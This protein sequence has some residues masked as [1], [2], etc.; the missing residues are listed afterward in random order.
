[1]KRYKKYISQTMAALLLG[2][3]AAGCSDDLGFEGNGIVDG[4]PVTLSVNCA[5]GDMPEVSR[6]DMAAGRD[7]EINSMWVAFFAKDGTHEKKYEFT[8]DNVSQVNTMDVHFPTLS[9][10][11]MT[12][13][14]Y[15]LVAVA[16]PAGNRGVT[17]TSTTPSDLMGLLTKVTT[18]E[19]YKNIAVYTDPG[20]VGTPTGNL[21]MQ[22]IYADPRN[23]TVGASTDF[24]TAESE[25]TVKVPAGTKTLA[26]AIHF[27][28]LISQVKFN[29]TY[30][31]QKFS[32]FEPVSATVYNV[33]S[34]S[35][36]AERADNRASGNKETNAGDNIGNNTSNN[37][38]PSQRFYIFSHNANTY[39]IDWYQMEN[40]RLSLE[41]N[42]IS[43]YSDRENERK[44][45]NL[46]TGIYI[47]LC[48]ETGDT[49]LHNNNASYVVIN[50]RMALRD[51]VTTS[52]NQQAT[53]T[54]EAT[55]TIHL[56][57]CEGTNDAE[58]ANDY[59]C[60]R[61]TKYTY[62]ITVK[63]VNKI[64]V[65]AKKQNDIDYEHGAE[66][67]IT[68]ITHDF[69]TADSHFEQFN[70]YF[71]ANELREF[72]WS[73]RVY[74]SPREFVTIDETNYENYPSKY[75]DWIEFVRTTGQNVCA[76]YPAQQSNR[77]KLTDIGK[78]S[79]GYY[80]MFIDEYIY[81]DSGDGTLTPSWKSYVNLPD[82]MAWLKVEEDRSSDTESVI[83]KSK[84]AVQQ[85]SLQTY[86]GTAAN[87]PEQA[88]ALEHVEETDGLSF[89][90]NGFGTSSR[91]GRFQTARM[92]D[93][94]NNRGTINTGN[95][96]PQWNTIL[97]MNAFYGNTGVVDIR[98]DYTRLTH[99]C[100]N[101]N[102]DLN[103]DGRIDASE[104]RWFVPSLN[105][106]VRFVMGAQS[107][108]SP[109]YDFSDKVQGA[110]VNYYHYG[111]S[112]G[113]TLWAEE[114]MSTQ[115]GNSG[116]ISHIR[117]ARYL[118]VNMEEFAETPAEPA[119]IKRDGKNEI[120][121]HYSNEALRDKTT[122]PLP[123]HYVNSEYNRPY[124]SLEYKATS[125]DVIDGNSTN[126]FNNWGPQT[127]T[128]N[129]WFAGIN[130]VNPCARF[131]T[132]DS[133]GWR[134]PNQVELTAILFSGGLRITNL[135]MAENSRFL[136][137]TREFFGSGRIMGATADLATA[138]QNSNMSTNAYILC[139]RDIE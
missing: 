34:Y 130:G 57:Y 66:G 80:T 18:L 58:K 2:A 26:G 100:L 92:L 10:L 118:G 8:Y 76:S 131:N 79:E 114:Y 78:A 69:F 67:I 20:T 83:V 36:L 60:R 29:I 45:N 28:R 73:V 81:E 35:W 90:I 27:R 138:I 40:R 98:S 133:R 72:K 53:R 106:Y 22:G 16:N 9:G 129:S 47:P 102:R 136:S 84:Y 5:V 12:S 126:P 17:E 42:N 103:G 19:E 113:Y 110:T 11:N 25:K 91:G 127:M 52:D 132:A 112:E 117:C 38:T 104:M 65:E 105:Q 14:E 120:E 122:S 101:R 128:V 70:V 64:E 134:V 119:F 30:D 125:T 95:N 116:A 86:Y 99:L 93:V 49:Y 50:A 23:H 41:Q 74:T 115:N 137:V 33:P 87:N 3:V 121:F 32:S 6:A 135:S 21:V 107:L 37:Y 111:S 54:V 88:L 24:W 59:N 61:N 44:D 4:E 108:S 15:Y 62:N 31:T 85:K 109:L 71:T 56:G 68:D 75:Y 94:L 63:D 13:G 97:N 51:P 123:W 82:R 1:M 43:K 89:T 39:S 48:G 46:N 7:K 96:R 139:V 124:K 77:I 55:Y